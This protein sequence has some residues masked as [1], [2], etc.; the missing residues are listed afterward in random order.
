MQLHFEHSDDFILGL[1]NLVLRFDHILH[2]GQS[3]FHSGEF[4]CQP[5]VFSHQI[6][7]DVHIAALTIVAIKV[8]RLK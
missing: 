3:F 7:V 8:L 5:L 4:S 6:G 2:L 1:D